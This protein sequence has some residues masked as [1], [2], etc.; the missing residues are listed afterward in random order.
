MSSP[1]GFLS[2]CIGVYFCLCQYHTVLDDCGLVVSSLRS[3]TL[4]PPA[5][6]FFLMTALA[7]CHLLCFHTNCEMFCSS[8]ME[9]AIDNLIGIAL[10]CR[11][12]WVVR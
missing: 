5:W 4:M 1:L 10:I 12:L 6:L 2:Y 3:G 11:L 7:V 9:N 8:S